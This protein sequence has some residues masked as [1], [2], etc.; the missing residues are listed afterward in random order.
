MTRIRRP[1]TA[2]LAAIVLPLSLA[3]CGSD[4]DGRPSK[5]DYRDGLQTILDN[6]GY[7]REQAAQNGVSE[8]QYDEYVTCVVDATYEELSDELVSEIAKGRDQETVSEADRT[9]LLDAVNTCA[10]TNTG[11]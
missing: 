9:A 6:T 10:V 8:D 11:N 2:S 3:A 7:S 1:L 5:E 4:S